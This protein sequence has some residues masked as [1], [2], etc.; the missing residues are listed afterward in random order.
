[1]F[2]NKKS[3]VSAESTEPLS[4]FEQDIKL[5]PVLKELNPDANVEIT[6]QNIDGEIKS[7]LSLM[8]IIVIIAE[9]AIVLLSFAGQDDCSGEMFCMPDFIVPVFFSGPFV[10][11]I[12]IGYFEKVS[13]CSLIGSIYHLVI[14]GGLLISGSTGNMLIL[15]LVEF[16]VS[17]ITFVISLNT[18]SLEKKK[19]QHLKEKQ[20]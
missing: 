4:R 17:V 18:R 11:M 15:L 1:M 8:L 20:S 3:I 13:I 12:M 6:P 16:L 19:K 14:Y 2:N 5:E 9:I 10:V 7:N